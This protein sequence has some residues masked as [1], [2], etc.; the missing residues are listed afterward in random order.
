LCLKFDISR[1]SLPFTY[2]C[3]FHKYVENID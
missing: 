3:N 1:F 2:V